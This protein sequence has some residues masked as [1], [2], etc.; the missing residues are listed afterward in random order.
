MDNEEI[1]VGEE[2]FAAFEAAFEEEGGNQTDTSE[3]APAEE[4]PDTPSQEPAEGVEE[5][6]QQEDGHGAEE[7]EDGAESPPAVD[8]FILRV[9]KEDRTVNREEVIALAQKGADYDRVKG[10]LTERDNTIATLTEQINAS[11]EPME[12]L[13]MISEETKTGIPEL[14]EQLHVSLRMRSGES[15]AEAKANI[16]AIKAER[17]VSAAQAAAKPAQPDPK[18]RAEREVAEFHRRFP[19]VELTE[20]LCGKLTDDVRKGMTI[21]DAYQKQREQEQANRIA[22]LERELAAERQNRKNKAISVGSQK[23][24]GGSRSKSTEDDFFAAFE[25]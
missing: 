24:S 22:Q 17:K 1:I 6:E 10:Q 7:K 9:N 8:T 25:K 13:A 12:L 4:S 19:G 3:E 20:E 21:A 16:R 11:K 2:D 15:E 14:L 5:G 18:E 23:D